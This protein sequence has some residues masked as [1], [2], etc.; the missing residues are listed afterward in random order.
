VFSA[1]STEQPEIFEAPTYLPA[2]DGYPI[3]SLNSAS[4]ATSTPQ[5]GLSGIQNQITHQTMCNTPLAHSTTARHAFLQSS[6][7]EDLKNSK[8][9]KDEDSEIQRICSE[10]AR[11]KERRKE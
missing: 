6:T 5:Q 11:L 1:G 8:D 9:A 7:T 3:S 2:V 4:Q 10:W